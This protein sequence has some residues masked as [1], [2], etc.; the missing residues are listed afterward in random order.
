VKIENRFVQQ[1]WILQ[2]NSV[3]LF[4]SHCGMGSS[5]EGIYFQKPILC[6]PFNMD[7]FINAI[8][9]DHLTIGLSLFV[10]PSLF[11]SLL[12]PHNFH[13]YT[14]SASSVTVKLLNLWKNDIYQKTIKIMSLE[15][16]Y[17]GGLKRAVEEIEFFVNLNGTLDRYAPFQSTLP[18]YQRYMLDLLI[19]FIVLPVIIVRYRFIKCRQRRR[20]EKN[21]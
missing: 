19:I 20:K 10:P 3:K 14:F 9:I 16:K 13:D 5:S 1:K 11:Q 4:L 21:D 15:M 12:N 18:F 7:Q 6:M 17:A 8:S 2:Q